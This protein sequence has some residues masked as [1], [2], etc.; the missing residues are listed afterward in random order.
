MENIGKILKALHRPQSRSH[1]GQNG[2]L[3][4]IGGSSKYSGSPVFEILAARRFVDLVY[5]YP[6]ETDPFL[7]QAVKNIPEAITVYELGK[8]EDAD[9]VLFGSGMGDAEFDTRAL[10]RAKKVVVDADGF[11]FINPKMLGPRFILTPHRL[12]FERFFGTDATQK[13]AA[14]MAKKHECT[15]LL[16]GVPDVITN[17]KRTFLNNTH[18]PGMKKGGTGDTLAGLTAALACTNGNFEAACAAAHANGLAGNILMKKYG[19]NFCASDLA[20][21]LAEACVQATKSR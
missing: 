2:K 7:V 11:K 9:C 1:K 18:N 21:T 13:N 10:D 3:L 5:F 14:A 20:D 8:V 6:G 4:I 16:K 17:G 15:I 12:E 19:F